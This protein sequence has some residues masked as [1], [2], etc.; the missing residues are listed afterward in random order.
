MVM[1]NWFKKGN[2]NL[3]FKYNHSDW[4]WADLGGFEFDYSCSTI[5]VRII[6]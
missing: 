3:N 4:I 2:F 5:G 1:L 6:F